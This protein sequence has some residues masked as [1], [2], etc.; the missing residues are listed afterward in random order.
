[1]RCPC[2]APWEGGWAATAWKGQ[3]Q[4]TGLGP[5]VDPAQLA[6]NS[7]GRCLSWTGQNQT[8]KA[9]CK[10]WVRPRR[11]SP[12]ARS[13]P[14]KRCPVVEWR[15]PSSP[16]ALGLHEVLWAYLGWEMEGKQA[17]LE[18]TPQP[19]L[20]LEDHTEGGDGGDEGLASRLGPLLLDTV[21]ECP[22]DALPESLRTGVPA[23]PPPDGTAARAAPVPSQDLCAVNG[24]REARVA[25][26]Q[27]FWLGSSGVK[28][29]Q[30]PECPSGH[31]LP[32]SGQ[33]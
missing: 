19:W 1:M 29:L 18:P 31:S 15:R 26:R 12:G 16:T 24:D 32:F 2:G 9:D 10:L 20:A 4:G 11:S 23:G 22:N 3:S 5:G 8:N 27:Q 13:G 21:A 6:V 14:H 33:E 7:D 25:S 28:A 30:A 17:W